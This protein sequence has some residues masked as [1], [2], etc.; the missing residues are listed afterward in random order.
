MNLVSE[1]REQADFKRKE[2]STLK[3]HT[4]HLITFDTDLEQVLKPYNEESHENSSIKG[5]RSSAFYSANQ[6]LYRL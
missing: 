6:K 3:K 2:T 1:T 5:K 4:S